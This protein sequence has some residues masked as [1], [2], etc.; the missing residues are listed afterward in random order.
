VQRDREEGDGLEAILDRSDSLRHRVAMAEQ[1]GRVRT[2][3]R[4]G[5]ERHYIYAGTVNIDGQIRSRVKLYGYPGATG[6]VAFA[7]ADDAALELRRIQS[8]I[9]AGAA[10]GEA[11][12]PYIASL[13]AHDMVEVKIAEYIA[14]QRRRM[15]RGELSAR[16]TFAD[17]ERWTQPGG[18]WSFW[19]GHRIDKVGRREIRQWHAWL[20]DRGLGDKTRKNVSDTFRT[21][22]RSWAEDSGAT[23]PNF[24]PIAVAEYAPKTIPMERVIALLDAIP[25]GKRGL[26][27]AIA[28]E[29]VRFSEAV[30]HTLED[31]DGTEIHW[32]RGRQGQTLESR[33]AKGKTK[34]NVRREPWSPMLREWLEWR[35]GQTTSEQAARGE[36][37]A[38]FWNPEAK[39][40]TKAWSGSSSRRV[41]ET[42]TRQCGERI[43]QGEAL[44]H[45]V[46]SELAGTL[47]DHALRVHSR[48]ASGGSLARY[49]KGAKPDFAAIVKTL[50]PRKK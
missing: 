12:K 44:R 21:F 38:L 29:S 7:S 4:G 16:G 10:P 48:H 17:L 9:I 13:V 22:L 27:L 8:E 6:V 45:S 2:E 41:W 40:K 28:F 26:W 37:T 32:H 20:A 23:A 43:S 19:G 5:S 33:I 36:A 39:N 3:R 47:P 46:L 25:W 31:W 18:H 34:S 24:P 30:A 11:I 14:D 1:F 35:A 49:T 50:T 42:A 15:E